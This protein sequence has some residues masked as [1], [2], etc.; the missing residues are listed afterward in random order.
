MRLFGS[1]RGGLASVL[2][3]CT[4]RRTHQFPIKISIN[5]SAHVS[6]AFSPLMYDVDINFYDLMLK[7]NNVQELVGLLTRYMEIVDK[8][9]FELR[10]PDWQYRLK[11]AEEALENEMVEEMAQKREAGWEVAMEVLKENARTYGGACR[12]G[13]AQRYGV[14]KM[15]A[16]AIGHVLRMGNAG[17]LDEYCSS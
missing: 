15:L 16:D 14:S 6:V 1:S 13:P 11:G 5:A 12:M 2:E 8:I 9:E 7:T 3:F 10:D 4:G 17:A